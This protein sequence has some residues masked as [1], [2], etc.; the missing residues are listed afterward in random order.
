VNLAEWLLSPVGLRP[1]LVNWDGVALYFLRG[2]HAD[3]LADGT[4]ETAA[5]LKRLLAIPGVPGLAQVPRLEEPPSPVLVM[6]FRRH[7]IDL[8]LF[9][10]LA[11]LGT[12]QD[13]TAQEIRVEC[14]FPADEAS[15][16]RFR[17]WA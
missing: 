8:R 3:A 2:V 6:H 9:T 15:A 17:D 4:T 16:Q 7:D 14:F 5:L 1:V 13:V 10:T 11:T 12:P